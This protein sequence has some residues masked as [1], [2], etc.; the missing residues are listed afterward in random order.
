[1]LLYVYMFRTDH[2]E[3]E[4]LSG[5][6]SWRSL[7][8]H[9]STV[10]TSYISSS[11]GPYK[12]S[13]MRVGIATIT[14]LCSSWLGHIVV[15]FS[16]LTLPR[17]VQKQVSFDKAPSLVSNWLSKY[18]SIHGPSVADNIDDA[19]NA[20][21]IGTFPTQLLNCCESCK[22]ICFIV[23]GVEKLCGFNQRYHFSV[24]GNADLINR[25]LLDAG[26][27]NELVQNYWSKQKN[28]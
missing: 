7:T 13:P 14:S 8:L 15:Q 22:Y 23:I 28:M 6:C 1:M 12:A 18:Q 9:L 4:I 24:L 10:I 16:Y 3:Q 20:Q 25:I 21:L 5:A 19:E 11:V 26:F 2:Q 17:H 27:T